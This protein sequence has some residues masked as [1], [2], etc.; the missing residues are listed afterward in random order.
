MPCFYFLLLSLVHEQEV[1]S[2][3]LPC[4]MDLTTNGRD[5]MTTSLLDIQAFW[6]LRGIRILFM[7]LFSFSCSAAR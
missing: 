1:M 6:V 5:L 4:S 2:G 7:F 3:R